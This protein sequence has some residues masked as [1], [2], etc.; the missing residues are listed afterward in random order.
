MGLLR[1]SRQD[2]ALVEND[3]K[4]GEI[5]IDHRTLP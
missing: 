5:L 2:D 4:V 3:I 1:P